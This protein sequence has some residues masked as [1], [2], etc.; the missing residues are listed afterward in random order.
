MMINIALG[1]TYRQAVKIMAYCLVRGST[2]DVELRELHHRTQKSLHWFQK[3]LWF[4]NYLE[5]R[6]LR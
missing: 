6:H 1:T 3:F 2:R 4:E 5:F